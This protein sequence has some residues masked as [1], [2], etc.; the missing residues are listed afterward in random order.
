MHSG[1]ILISYEQ[2]YKNLVCA[3][4]RLRR[5]D[6]VGELPSLLPDERRP[7]HLLLITCSSGGGSFGVQ[8]ALTRLLRSWPVASRERCKNDLT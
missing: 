7:L 8:Q 4:A 2:G 6:N 3:V 1:R 5:L